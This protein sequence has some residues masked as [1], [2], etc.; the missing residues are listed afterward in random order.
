MAMTLNDITITITE[1]PFKGL[2]YI[3]MDRLHEVPCRPQEELDNDPIYQKMLDFPTPTDEEFAEFE[4]RMKS[5][6]K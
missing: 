1:G 4:E 3:D 6:W 5:A 2:K